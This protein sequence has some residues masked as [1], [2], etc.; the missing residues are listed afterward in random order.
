MWRG[1]VIPHR[2][3]ERH[4]HS[5]VCR[6]SAAMRPPQRHPVRPTPSGSTWRPLPIG[7]IVNGATGRI[8]STQHL[9]NALVAD[10][11]RGRT[12]ASATIASCR[13]CCSPDATPSASPRSHGHTTSP[14][15]RPTS[16]PRSPTP[17]M[18]SSSTPPRPSSASACCRKAI[19]AGKHIYS[20][21]PV[22]PTV[23]PR[24][25]NCCG[26][27]EARGL[28]HGAVEDK[29]YLPGLQK[30]ARLMRSRRAR[31]H[32]RLPARVRLVGVRR[33]RPARP[34][35]ELELSPRRR[36]RRPDP[37]YVSALALHHRD[38]PRPH[39]R[40]VVGAVGPRSR[41]GSTNRA[42]A[43]RSTSKMPPRRWSNSTTAPSARS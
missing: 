14:T 41:S 25:S 26:R 17:A 4:R 38:D 19:A 30:L 11:R 7:I 8:A 3:H 13:V 29:L 15:G 23:A 1:T 39:R 9:A 18:R 32:R 21:K 24:R 43:T 16:T 40:G 2:G 34:A 35:A 42:S 27:C 31:P 6:S 5:I 33:H 12:A 22:A 10:P 20:E 28:R 37:R 36:R